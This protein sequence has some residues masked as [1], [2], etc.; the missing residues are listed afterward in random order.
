MNAKIDSTQVV[1]KTERPWASEALQAGRWKNGRAGGP[2][3]MFVFTKLPR[4]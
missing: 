2:C 1:E 4:V 3:R